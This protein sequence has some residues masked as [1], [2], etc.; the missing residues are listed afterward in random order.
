L[1]ARNVKSRQE[2]AVN[3]FDDAMKLFGKLYHEDGQISYNNDKE[4]AIVKV[5]FSEFYPIYKAAKRR[6]GRWFVPKRNGRPSSRS[7]W[8]TRSVRSSTPLILLSTNNVLLN[9]Q[10]LTHHFSSSN[11]PPP[12]SSS[13]LLP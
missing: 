1:L 12:S 5:A 4:K 10:V 11:A 8:T 2:K 7:T 9:L 3:D 6:P 13:N